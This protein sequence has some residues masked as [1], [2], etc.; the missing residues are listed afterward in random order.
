MKKIVLYFILMLWASTSFGQKTVYIPRFITRVNMDLNNTSSQWCYARSMQSDNVV[1]FWEPGYGID[2]LQN[3]DPFYRVNVKNILDIAENSY[4]IYLDSLKFAIRG[5]SVTDRYKLMIFLLYTR[6][7]IANGS[8]QDDLVGTLHV[9]PSGARALTIAHEIGHCFQ[10]ITGC[11]TDGGF[12]YGFGPNASG[13]NGF[14]E[15]MAN[16]MAFRVYPT[17]IFTG[18]NYYVEYEPNY[19][20][21]ILHWYPRYADHF[22]GAFWAFKHDKTIIARLWRESRRPEDPIETYKR[23]TSITQEQFNDQM[24]EHGSRLTTWDLPTTRPYGANYINSKPQVRMNLTSDNYWLVDKSVAVENYGYNCIRL[25]VPTRAT[26]VQVRFKGKAGE[27]GYRTLNMTKGGWRYGFVA[28]L[29]DGTRVYSDMG[30]AR[31]TNGANPAEQTLSFNCPANCSRLWLVVTGAPQ[32]HWRHAWDDNYDNDESW[33]YQVQFTNTNLL[34]N[35]TVIT[36]LVHAWKT[37]RTPT[38][39]TNNVRKGQ[40]AC[41]ICTFGL[42]KAGTMEV[43]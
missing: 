28:L 3:T 35:A 17:Q 40:E 19:F 6:D 14:W 20:R 43:E 29:N 10:Y 23:I 36:A 32:E 41:S 5:S 33:P 37:G 38:I 22:I 13:G 30:T 27:P 4:K 2:P 9:N 7:G 8:G 15:Q 34:G 11:D 24:Y 42:Q 39:L 21:N 12:Q 16:W 1:I 31:V 25:N 18:N 26:Q